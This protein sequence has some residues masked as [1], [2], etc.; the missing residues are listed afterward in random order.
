MSALLGGYVAGRMARFDGAPNGLLAGLL[1]ALLLALMGA[2]GAYSAAESGL[3]VSLDS[4]RLTTAALLAFGAALL[5][6][7]LT[8]LLGGRLGARW[9]RAVDDVVVGTRPG[10]VAMTGAQVVR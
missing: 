3:P 8:G 7:G 4:D 10:A 5:V 9:H 6:S 1:M 2:T